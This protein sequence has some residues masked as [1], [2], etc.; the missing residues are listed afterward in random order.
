M[1]DSSAG[2]LVLHLNHGEP[3]PERGRGDRHFYYLHGPGPTVVGTG[4]SANEVLLVK[5]RETVD[6]VN[7]LPRHLKFASLSLGRPTFP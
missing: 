6:Q 2:T 7:C 3:F 1:R 5:R 4:Y